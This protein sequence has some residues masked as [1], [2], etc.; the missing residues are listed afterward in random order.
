[1]LGGAD[2]VTDILHPPGEIVPV[3]LRE[4]GHPFENPL[5]LKGLPSVFHRIPG[6]VENH[7][8]GVQVRVEGPGFA[9]GVT[10]GDDFPGDSGVI[11]PLA[12]K[13]GAG[14]LLHQ[15]HG[16]FGGGFVGGD[17]AIV[18]QGDGHE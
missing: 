4:V 14:F 16:R 18:P 3:D 12:P 2:G 9:V 5:R 13:P 7:V 17:Q 6:C 8:M 15:R 11:H 10:G 1:M